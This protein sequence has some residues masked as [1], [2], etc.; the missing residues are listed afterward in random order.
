MLLDPEH[1][2]SEP[3]SLVQ[4]HVLI[5]RI[6]LVLHYPLFRRSILSFHQ[7]PSGLEKLTRVQ[8]SVF[9]TLKAFCEEISLNHCFAFFN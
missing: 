2:S 4:M 5:L 3:S 1:L 7:G 6:I 8:T 9:Q